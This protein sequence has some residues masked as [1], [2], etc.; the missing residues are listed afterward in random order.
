MSW[1]M[2]GVNHRAISRRYNASNHYTYDQMATEILMLMTKNKYT[3]ESEETNI[4]VIKN[5]K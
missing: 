3:S 5:V 1:S 2:I 4:H